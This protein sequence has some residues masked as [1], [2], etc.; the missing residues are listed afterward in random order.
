MDTWSCPSA[1]GSGAWHQTHGCHLPTC[2]YGNAAAST[3]CSWQ[4][5]EMEWEWD[6]SAKLDNAFQ[7][8]CIP[9]WRD[10]LCTKASL[11]STDLE[12][13]PVAKPQQGCCLRNAGGAEE[14]R[15]NRQDMPQGGYG[16]KVHLSWS[17]LEIIHV[18]KDKLQINKPSCSTMPSTASTGR[19]L[20]CCGDGE[21]GDSD[22]VWKETGCQQHLHGLAE[23]VPCWQ[24]WE[25]LP[26]AGVAAGKGRD[27]RITLPSPSL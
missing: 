3:H 11:K 5:K 17:C 12:K 25:V 26:G 7:A 20:V 10:S 27:D 24:G 1:A 14:V 9:R 15:W 2:H 21:G 23:A 22:G 6:G 13:C 4:M 19:F 16:E 8:L 18:H